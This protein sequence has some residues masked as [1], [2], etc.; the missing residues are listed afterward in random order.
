VSDG[1][2]LWFW[3][4]ALASRRCVPEKRS[5]GANIH[6]S[7]S[8]FQPSSPKVV[9]D[10]GHL[11]LNGDAPFA[12][13]DINLLGTNLREHAGAGGHDLSCAQR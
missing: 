13:G 5:L 8:I 4:V 3:F 9:V 10:F 7:T 1:L 2:L 11:V 12:F 6:Y